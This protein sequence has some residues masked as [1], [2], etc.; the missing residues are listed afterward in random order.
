MRILNDVRVTE[1]GLSLRF[2][3][4]YQG[5]VRA[6]IADAF[7]YL[8][9][10]ARLTG[11]MNRR[12][13]MMAGGRMAIEK[14]EQA[15][16]GLGASVR[17]SGRVLGIRLRVH[18]IVTM[19][20]PPYRK[21]WSTTGAPRLLVIGPYRMGFTLRPSLQDTHLCV[22]IDYD[23]PKGLAGRTLGWLA[24]SWYARWCTRRMV[25]DAERHFALAQT[26]TGR[27]SGREALS[28]DRS[29][30]ADSKRCRGT[31]S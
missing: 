21:S 24:G 27:A 22:S 15:G 8:D 23:L 5:L 3:S 18:E 2:H 10:H 4:E 7:D 31:A 12:S 11:H 30:T 29:P 14:D 28:S 1:A 13:W 16:R 17:L 25:V 6:S 9:D 20:E 19:Y 26:M